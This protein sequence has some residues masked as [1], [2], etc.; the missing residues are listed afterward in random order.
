MDRYVLPKFK[1]TVDFASD[2]AAARHGYR[3]G[4]HVTGT[5]RAVYFF[6][7][8]V[9]RAEVSIKTLGMDVAQFDAASVAGKTDDAGAY[10]FDVTLPAY[11]AGRPLSQGAARV[12]IEA[13]VKDAAGHAETRGE[14]IVVSQSPLLITAIPEG[15]MLIPNLENQVF[16]LT[17]YADGQAR[18]RR[19]DGQRAGTPGTACD[20]GCWRRRDRAHESRSG[21][22][23]VTH[24]GARPRRQSGFRDDVARPAE[25][26]RPDSA[27]RR[28]SCLSRRRPHCAQ[29]VLRKA[30][31]VGVHRRSS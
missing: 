4:D 22:A 16:I 31:R 18:P 11:F 7:K 8:P 9:D 1:V 3:P 27:A 25:R 30:K 29:S 21:C 28:A 15:G 23:V 10:R 24:R 6:G 2:G 20:R 12:L 26:L 13:T 17:S 19:S 5:V 14:P